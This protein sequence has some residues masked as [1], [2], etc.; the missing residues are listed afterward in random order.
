MHPRA[1]FLIGRGAA[2]QGC[3]W[4]PHVL[5]VAHARPGMEQNL[6]CILNAEGTA[7]R[8]RTSTPVSTDLFASQGMSIDDWTDH[9]LPCWSVDGEAG[10]LLIGT[11]QAAFKARQHRSNSTAIG[12]V[13]RSYITSVHHCYTLLGN[14]RTCVSVQAGRARVADCL[15]FDRPP[16]ARLDPCVHYPLSNIRF[17]VLRDTQRLLVPPCGN[18]ELLLEARL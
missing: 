8:P 10:R 12:L 15:V 9:R 2:W 14:K 11:R 6:R 7:S 13:D 1:R 3:R 17:V 5:P 4:L 16:K 18:V